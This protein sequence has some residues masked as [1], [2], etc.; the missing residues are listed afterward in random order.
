MFQ[1]S[2]AREG[3]FI[4]LLLAFF[5][6]I[7]TGALSFPADARLFPVVLSAPCILSCLVLLGRQIRA[8]RREK[9]EAAAKPIRLRSVF[10]FAFSALYFLLA[11]V[12]GY[13]LATLL[14]LLLVPPYLGYRS[15]KGILVNA[16][17]VF[18][19]VI[20]VFN[21]LLKLRCYPGLLGI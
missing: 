20:V 3:L 6:F 9:T 18:L 8:F 17:L 16:V 11:Y 14:V 12:L 10:P 15:A 4:L 19:L 2:E 5:L 1:R 13:Y 21:L 7:F